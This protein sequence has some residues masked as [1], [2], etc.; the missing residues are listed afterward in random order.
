MSATLSLPPPTLLARPQNINAPIREAWQSA[1]M[2]PPVG[3]VRFICPHTGIRFYAI[4]D[5]K[6]G[7]LAVPGTTSVQSAAAPPEEKQRLIDWRRRE[8]AAGRD[9]DKGRNRGSAVHALL[10][11]AVRGDRHLHTIGEGEHTELTA[12]A[13]GMEKH[14]RP[15]DSFLWNERP[16]IKGWDH[17]WSARD[18]KG[19]RLARV[20]SLKWGF[21]GT[22]DLIGVRRWGKDG[23]PV[24]V[25]RFG[26]H[27]LDHLAPV[28]VHGNRRVASTAAAE[29]EAALCIHDDELASHLGHVGAVFAF[30]TAA[31]VAAITPTTA[32]G[33]R[34]LGDE[35]GAEQ[36]GDVGVVVEPELVLLRLFVDALAAPDHLEE[37]DR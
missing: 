37:L 13:S 32:T 17:C 11:N 27:A 24:E 35:V 6:G 23:T 7:Q 2:R 18:A 14:L 5:G 36:A 25:V 19:N 15:Y 10:E 9:P 3:E 34:R 28:F 33:A 12:W 21:A 22:P 26:N 8:I 29:D 30:A 1:A 20:W 4:P 16:L 31:G